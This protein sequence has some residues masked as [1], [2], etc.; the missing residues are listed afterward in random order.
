MLPSFESKR[1][2]GINGIPYFSTVSKPVLYS[3]IW[4]LVSIFLMIFGMYHC[5]S[6]A[7]SFDFK[8]TR[9]SCS[10]VRNGDRI[11]EIEFYRDDLLSSSVVKLNAD[12]KSVKERLPKNSRSRG[13]DRSQVCSLEIVL[14]RTSHPHN[15]HQS[16]VLLN[17]AD[18]GW[19]N[20]FK[21]NIL[22]NISLS[23][24]YS[25]SQPFG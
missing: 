21:I 12:K 4:L 18:I 24:Y 2:N 5:Y 3:V 1:N 13:Q 9:D 25:N 22:K 10:L 7:H 6:N 15:D 16:Q 23:I 20:L 11:H 19:W 14:K 17:H 8:C